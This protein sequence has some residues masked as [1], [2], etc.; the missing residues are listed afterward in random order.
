MPKIVKRLVKAFSCNNNE[1][2]TR[3]YTEGIT[4]IEQNIDA[5][6]LYPGEYLSV[7][8]YAPSFCILILICSVLC[9]FGVYLFCI[10][11]MI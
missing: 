4:V 10:Y 9:I 2:A 6:D 5:V 1:E 7:G 8:T 11:S 3:A